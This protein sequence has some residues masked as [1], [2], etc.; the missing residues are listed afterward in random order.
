MRHL[1]IAYKILTTI[2]ILGI[3]S[4]VI[5]AYTVVQMKRV[6]TSYTTLLEREVR[7]TLSTARANRFM[8][9]SRTSAVEMQ[10]TTTPEATNRAMED[11][12][13]NR[14]AFIVE[15]D[16]AIAS[17]PDNQDL[18]DLKI[19]G[20]NILDEVCGNVVKLAYA[21]K[22]DQENLNVQRIYFAE[23][24][25]A[26]DAYSALSV[27]V[28]EKL[29]TIRKNRSEDLGAQT[30]ST[31][32]ITISG[33][34]L[35]IGGAL[36]LCYLFVRSQIVRPLRQLAETMSIIANGNLSADVTETDR[37]DEVGLMARA[38]LLFKENGLKA[39]AL[40]QEAAD[41]RNQSE[42]ERLRN[43]EAERVRA[44]Q[45][46]EATGGLAEGL[47]HLAEGNLTFELS[48]P[49]AQEFE[50]LRE[51]FNRTVSQLR[52]TMSAVSAATAAIDSGSRELSTSAN[53]LSKRTE[54]QAAA[55]EETAAALDQITANVTSA[56]KRTEEARDLAGQANRSARQSGEVVAN[57]VNAMER[58]ENSSSQ[59]S[60]IIGVIDEIAFQTNLL[61]LNAGVEAARAGDAGKG[62]AVVAQEVR[63]LA[64]RSAQAAK[65]IKDLIRN[66]AEEVENGVRLVS[67]TGEVLKIIEEHV[68]TINSQLDAISTSAR[69]Q[70]VGL[71]EVN[72]AVNQMDQVTQQNAAMVEEATA[73]S[74]S[75]ASEAD[76]LRQLVSQFRIDANAGATSYA[77]AG[78]TSYAATGTG[79]TRAHV[80]TS[81]STAKP[82]TARPRTG[83][84]PAPAGRNHAPAASPA[85]NMVGH[86]AKAL[87]LSSA[88]AQ[89]SWEEF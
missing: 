38:L 83:A 56:S 28:V 11:F 22:T 4:L 58:I 18:K 40:E 34:I 62:F 66:S 68:I 8:Q 24:K 5:A 27:E 89:D 65:E 37:R 85:R 59:I 49:F 16:K 39:R 55:L 25:S 44:G 51:N 19:K 35:S 12:K 9:A 82:V 70:S 46:A 57:A 17:L 75:L 3:L 71:S 6:D 78:A 26:F 13:K 21:A 50:E 74:T 31:V 64:Q 67:A 43:A 33:V 84:K 42:A 87:G 7:A 47:R 54:Q 53:D 80:V 69:E 61:A 72:S 60:N 32:T 36:L 63:E 48:K 52:Q 2:A 77:N 76:R 20:L 45:M 79:S 30:D 41:T 88:A 14:E 23:C 29:N 81:P 10:I 1:P 86:V 73:A 15:A